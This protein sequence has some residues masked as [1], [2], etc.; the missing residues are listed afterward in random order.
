R[1]L[2][3]DF[4]PA[5]SVSRMPDIAVKDFFRLSESGNG[6]A[7]DHPDFPVVNDSVMQYPRAPGDRLAV[8]DERPVL[9]VTR[10][11]HVELIMP[12]GHVAADDPH[13][14]LVYDIAGRVPS[15]PILGRVEGLV[16]ETVWLNQLPIFAVG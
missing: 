16:E 4:G 5:N 13:F 11:P 2:R 9:A 3:L 8:V 14:V 1:L 12:L 6:L 10:I 15:F 7:A